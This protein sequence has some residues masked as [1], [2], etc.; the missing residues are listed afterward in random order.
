MMRLKE[1]DWCENCGKQL[2]D[3]DYSNWVCK[4]CGKEFL[5]LC[6]DCI[7]AT[8]CDY[9]GCTDFDPVDSFIVDGEPVMF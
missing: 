6:R 7:E 8:K 9:C 5:L 4:K 1:P 3:F 2:S